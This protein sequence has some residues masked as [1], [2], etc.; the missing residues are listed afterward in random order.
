M[1]EFMF[2]KNKKAAENTIFQQAAKVVEEANEV[3]EAVAE[4]DDWDILCETYDCINACEGILR[5]YPDKALRQKAHDFVRDKCK[6]RGDY[7]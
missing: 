3:L 1:G 6:N 5:K 4:M 7:E 2:P